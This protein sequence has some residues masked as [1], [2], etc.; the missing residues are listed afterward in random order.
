MKTRQLMATGI[1]PLLIRKMSKGI[2][3]M[4]TLL[5]R[6]NDPYCIKSPRSSLLDR[7]SETISCGRPKTTAECT[8]SADKSINNSKF[9]SREQVSAQEYSSFGERRLQDCLLEEN[10]V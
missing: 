7:Q 10:E 4:S 8:V 5:D 3:P 1:A 9:T 2:K 6:I